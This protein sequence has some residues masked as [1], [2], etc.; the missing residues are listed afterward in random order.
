MPQISYDFNLVVKVC[1]LVSVFLFLAALMIVAATYQGTCD[2]KNAGICRENEGTCPAQIKYYVYT[3]NKCSCSVEHEDG[4]KSVE[5]KD[6]EY[7]YHSSAVSVTVIGVCFAV[8]PY[9]MLAVYWLARIKATLVVYILS[10]IYC[11]IVY[12]IS[13]AKLL[14]SAMKNLLFHDGSERGEHL[15]VPIGN[16]SAEIAINIDNV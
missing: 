5:C 3:I 10:G 15:I 6:K 12:S 2:L 13:F 4:K 16:D 8:L 14:Y 9:A 1:R 7:N 11:S